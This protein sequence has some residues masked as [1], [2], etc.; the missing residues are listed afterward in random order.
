VRPA[1]LVQ[2]ARS[3]LRNPTWAFALAVE[4][5]GVG[6]HAVALHV[7]ALV[8]VQSL[9]VTS[10]L[11]ALVV[12]SRLDR[13]VVTVP[14][15][16]WAVVLTVG[17]AVFLVAAGP[18]EPKLQAHVTAA[19]VA[20]SVVGA[21]V[22]V[23]AVI[24]SRLAS[25]SARPVLLGAA[26]GLAFAGTAALVKTSGDLLVSR[27]VAAL[28][29][30]WASWATLAVGGA[31]AVLGQ[32]AFQAGPLAA[33]LPAIQTVGPVMSVVLGAAVYE[34]QLHNG[35]GALCAEVA[36]LVAIVVATVALSQGRAPRVTGRRPRLVGPAGR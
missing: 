11:F 29:D 36:G 9:L 33:S 24:A 12:R 1:Q 6:L 34:E 8:L 18:G 25:P 31:G 30:S 27:G 17:L 21:L 19:G 14:E 22:L 13:R 23:G 26:A 16:G 4:A 32:L 28:V 3:V 7:G 2:F 5:V 35:V 15:M 20:V 10:V